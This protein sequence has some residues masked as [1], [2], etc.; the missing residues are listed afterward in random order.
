M[1]GLVHAV[2]KCRALFWVLGS[3]VNK[4]METPALVGGAD[5]RVENQSRARAQAGRGGGAA[6][7]EGRSGAP[8]CGEPGRAPGAEGASAG[9]LRQQAP[10]VCGQAAGGAGAEG[11][12]A[13]AGE[14]PEADGAHPVALLRAWDWLLGVLGGGVM[15]PRVREKSQI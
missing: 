5:D 14:Q 7:W 6:P 8:C 11:Q 10:P 2:P 15:L 9:A 4:Q 3:V 1:S 13:E 12:G